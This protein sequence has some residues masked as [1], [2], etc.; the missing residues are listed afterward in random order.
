M[1]GKELCLQ[2]FHLDVVERLRQTSNI[3]ESSPKD[4]EK[5]WAP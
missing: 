1:T 5:S 4:I 2:G 3:T